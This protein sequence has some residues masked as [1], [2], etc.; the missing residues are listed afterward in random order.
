MIFASDMVDL[1]SLVG[2]LDGN[3]CSY[4]FDRNSSGT[5]GPNI[6]TRL[7]ERVCVTWKSKMNASS[8]THYE[9]PTRSYDFSAEDQPHS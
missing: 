3:A 6:G 5:L 1:F 4:T 9:S 7:Q 8:Q 2:T